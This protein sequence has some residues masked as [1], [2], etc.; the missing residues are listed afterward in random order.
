MQSITH[1]TVIPAQHLEHEGYEVGGV[2]HVHAPQHVL[3]SRGLEEQWINGAKVTRVLF[4]TDL[5]HDVFPQQLQPLSLVFALTDWSPLS[6]SRC[7]VRMLH[8]L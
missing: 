1:H 5:S 2:G 8:K 4:T 7:L 3:V 6:A